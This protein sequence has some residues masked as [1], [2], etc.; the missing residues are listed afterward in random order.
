MKSPDEL[1][2]HIGARVRLRRMTLGMSQEHLGKSIGLTFQQIQKYE[3]GLNR[4]GAGRLYRIAMVLTVP[5][6]YFFE[7][8]PGAEDLSDTQT[9]ERNRAI[10]SFLVSPDGFS[11]CQAFLSIDD[12][13]T[14]RRIVDLV[15]TIA[16]ETA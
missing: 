6:E 13:A 15:A 2:A 7:G 4:I 16:G 3:K 10:Q 8:L 5:V 14:R 1:D 12:P 11:L 9:Q